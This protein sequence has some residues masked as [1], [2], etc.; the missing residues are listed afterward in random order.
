MKIHIICAALLSVALSCIMGI[1]GAQDADAWR[2]L[3]KELGAQGMEPE[4]WGELF[5]RRERGEALEPKEEAAAMENRFTVVD[6]PGA[7]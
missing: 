4:K 7:R 6:P 3:R 1:A 5:G 2:R